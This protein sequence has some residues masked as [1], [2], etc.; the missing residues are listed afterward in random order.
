MSDKSTGE[1]IQDSE[2]NYKTICGEYDEVCKQLAAAVEA[3]KYISEQGEEGTTLK[4]KAD[5]ALAKIKPT[6]RIKQILAENRITYDER[7]QMLSDEIN[8][9][10]A[11]ER[12]EYKKALAAACESIEHYKCELDT[13]I[14]ALKR[15]RE[16]DG[17][18]SVEWIDAKLAKIGGEK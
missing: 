18:A 4:S 9:A 5:A 7:I 14:E 15:I 2:A 11:A 10:L 16:Q 6:T 8:A 12:E 17:I 13:A 1:A 3:L